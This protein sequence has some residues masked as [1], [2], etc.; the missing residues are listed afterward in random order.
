MYN[1]LG[2]NSY[3]L[4]KNNIENKPVEIIDSQDLDI[5]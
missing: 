2:N 3:K 4:F 5:F 1:R